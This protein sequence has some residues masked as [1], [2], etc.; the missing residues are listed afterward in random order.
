[1]S[2]F[3]MTESKG[4]LHTIPKK[5]GRAI[6]DKHPRIKKEI[7]TENRG[8]LRSTRRDRQYPTSMEAPMPME[9]E[10]NHLRE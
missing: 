6:T 2:S 8:G 3:S 1:M 9:R 10:L 4:V 5:E 7:S